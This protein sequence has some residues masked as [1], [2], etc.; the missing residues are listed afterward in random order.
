MYT[1]FE[2][3]CS[4]NSTQKLLTKC[5][6]EEKNKHVICRP[7]SFRIGKNC[8]LGLEYGPRPAASGRTQ[9]P[10]AQFFPIRTSR[11]ANNIY[12]H[13]LMK[14]KLT[15]HVVRVSVF[16]LIIIK[17]DRLEKSFH[18]LG[19]HVSMRVSK[20]SKTISIRPSASWFNQFCCVGNLM[21]H[22]PSFM[23]HY[24]LL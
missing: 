13:A 10:L 9:R 24:F 3:G 17:S 1:R 19:F 7:R 15:A 16:V 2:N 14:Q 22:P 20:H 12:V 21:K 23:I 6:T 11:P 5:S 4:E 8:A 18:K